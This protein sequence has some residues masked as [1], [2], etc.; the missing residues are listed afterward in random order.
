MQFRLFSGPGD[1]ETLTIESGIRFHIRFMIFSDSR[2]HRTRCENR[3]DKVDNGYSDKLYWTTKIEKDEHI[4][5]LS[6]RF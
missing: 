6:I 2:S 1:F 4:H 5:F 3:L